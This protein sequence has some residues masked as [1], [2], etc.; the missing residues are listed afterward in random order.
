MPAEKTDRKQRGRPFAKGVSG[1]PDGRPKGALNWTTLAC[2]ELL[3]GEAETITRKA[4]E[5]AFSIIPPEVG[6]GFRP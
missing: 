2:Q 6:T 4:V 5:G 3:D 1:N